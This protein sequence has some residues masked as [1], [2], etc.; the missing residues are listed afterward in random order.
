MSAQ[1]VREF[2][3]RGE[4]KEVRA[5]RRQL[6][7]R[8]EAIPE[9]LEAMTLPFTVKDE[10]ELKDV[11]PGDRVHFTLVV[12]GKNEWIKGVAV[13][14]KGSNVPPPAEGKMQAVKLGEQLP[15][16]SLVTTEGKAMHLHD[17]KG[18]PV[19]ITFIFTRCPLPDM[20]P[21]LSQKFAATAKILPDNARLLSVSIDPDNDTPEVLAQYA[22]RHIAD[23][24]HWRMATGTLKEIT[25]LALACGADF[26]EEQGFI[27][28]N[29]RT[30][31]VDAEGKLR[32]VFADQKW[33]S[34]D[35]VT[36]LLDFS[37]QRQ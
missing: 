30:V 19:A 37:K 2:Q 21:L 4:V 29:L 9:Y 36:E 33:T 31:V 13:D 11:H 3:V 14:G 16:V 1:Q 27:S 22:A 7:V 35:L 8:H 34:E 10:A 28:H 6:V 12:E 18:H 25:R 24:T 26:W 15:N 23:G 5:E 32:R 17:L 20:C